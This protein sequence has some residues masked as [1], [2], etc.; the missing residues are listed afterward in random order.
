MLEKDS[1]GSREGSGG[2]LRG[3]AVILNNLPL[4][5]TSFAHLCSNK[6]RYAYRETCTQGMLNI[7]FLINLTGWNKR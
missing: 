4:N 1:G 2:S 6:R 5:V 7:D 3:V